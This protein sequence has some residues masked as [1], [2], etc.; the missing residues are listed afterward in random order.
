M[1]SDDFDFQVLKNLSGDKIYERLIGLKGVGEWTANYILM[2][3]FRIQEA[4]PYG[5]A[6][7][8]QALKKQL[9]LTSNP[10]REQIDTFFKPASGWEAYLTFYL[11][12][13]LSKKPL[14]V[15]PVTSTL[16]CWSH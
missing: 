1:G 2:K 15:M 5:D 13:S 4:I 16:Y 10:T 14:K 12:R 9:S 8:N 6:G 3:T 7:L 11:W